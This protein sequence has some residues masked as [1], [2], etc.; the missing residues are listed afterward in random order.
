MSIDTHKAVKALI[1]AGFNEAQAEAIVE[2]R[3][4]ELA[5]KTDLQAL[6]QSIEARFQALEQ[7]TRADI[8][9]LE[10]STRADIQALEQST[11]ADIQVLEQSTKTD[12]QSL[13]A[14]MRELELRITVR[15][16]AML[17]AASGLV[18]AILKIFP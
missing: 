5:T 11:R 7:S 2:T 16:G 1:D 13:R 3:H 6:E 14:E 17:F 15:M 10:Q 18:V 9:A 12:F 4:S 8:Q